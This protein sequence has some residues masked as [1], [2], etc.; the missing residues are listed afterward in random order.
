MSVIRDEASEKKIAVNSL[1]FET[2]ALLQFAA[3]EHHNETWPVANYVA[4]IAL[5]ATQLVVEF[6]VRVRRLLTLQV[7]L[8]IAVRTCGTALKQMILL[9]AYAKSVIGAS[10]ETRKS[11][12]FELCITKEVI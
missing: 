6:V 8:Q 3:V 11:N 12:C 9:R 2:S 1:C 5:G 7:E 10:S 4:R